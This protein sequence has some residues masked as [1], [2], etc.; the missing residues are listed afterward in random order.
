M[1]ADY[2]DVVDGQ[3]DTEAQELLA[4]Q[5]QLIHDRFQTAESAS[6][7]VQWAA[8]KGLDCGAAETGHRHYLHM[9]CCALRKALVGS[10]RAAMAEEEVR[11]ACV[12]EVQRHMHF[13]M[14]RA[15]VFL[16]SDQTAD[17]VFRIKSYIASHAS[18]RAL[19]LT[20]KSGAGKTTLLARIAHDAATEAAQQ[21][22]VCVARFVGASSDAMSVHALLHGMCEQLLRA[23]RKPDPIPRAFPDLVLFFKRAVTAW[24]S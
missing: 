4:G 6:I 14:Q 11:D 23:Y 3:L 22:R 24:P 16:Q 5:Q 12:A 19:L 9:M 17:V 1:A 10:L 7:K 20:G 21:G 18:G 2:I 8:G 15:S 13:A